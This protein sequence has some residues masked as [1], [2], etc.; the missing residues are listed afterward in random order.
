MPRVTKKNAL[1]HLKNAVEILFTK[2][3]GEAIGTIFSWNGQVNVFGAQ[4]FRDFTARN[5]EEI[6]HSLILSI[7]RPGTTA[8]PFSQPE[9]DRAN[10]K[11]IS[12]GD[13]SS[14]P[15]FTLRRLVVWITQRTTGN[16]LDICSI[17]CVSQTSHFI[18]TTYLIIGIKSP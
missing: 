9:R 5:K 17:F 3:T 7:H 10:L 8:E 2:V 15:V 11:L 12:D 13:F 4:D 18:S 14:L 1:E 16:W 6:W